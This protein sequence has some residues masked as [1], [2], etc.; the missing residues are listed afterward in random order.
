MFVQRF[1]AFSNRASGEVAL[2][3]APLSLSLVRACIEGYDNQEIQRRLAAG[4]KIQ[5]RSYYYKAITD[6]EAAREIIER[7]QRDLKRRLT[8]GEKR[9]LLNDNTSW[10]ADHV[11]A[12]VA[13]LYPTRG[14][15][16]A[17]SGGKGD[18]AWHND[19]YVTA[20]NMRQA[21]DMIEEK[22]V[23]SDT[24]IDLIEIEE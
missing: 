6:Q 21:L 10:E 13:E 19:L 12:I 14:Y 3:D 9:D 5:T 15:H 8:P 4:E 24:Q 22:I 1:H 17:I 18:A 7:A 11:A 20:E 16:A 23:G 2:F